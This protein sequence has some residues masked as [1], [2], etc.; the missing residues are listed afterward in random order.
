MALQSS[1]APEHRLKPRLEL[2]Q[3]TPRT[4]PHGQHLAGRAVVIGDGRLRRA[5]PDIWE[6]G[7]AMGRKSGA[8]ILAI[9]VVLILCGSLLDV[10]FSRLGLLLAGGAGIALLLDLLDQRWINTRGRTRR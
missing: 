3:A 5:W 2:H 6:K 1:N 10:G 4:V 9:G 8:F 7:A